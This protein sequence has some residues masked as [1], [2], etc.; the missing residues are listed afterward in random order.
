MRDPNRIPKMTEK[1]RALW[2]AYPDLR[3]GQLVNNLAPAGRNDAYYVED[4][5]LEEEI[6][7]QLQMCFSESTT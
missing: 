1:L 6:D 7:K 3:L 2:M 4:D 5:A